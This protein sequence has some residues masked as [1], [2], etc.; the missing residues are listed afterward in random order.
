[1]KRIWL[2]IDDLHELCS[3][4]V[5]RQLELL[6]MRAPAELR[7][8]LVSRR[9]LHLGLHR[10]R[11]EGELTE[12]RAA[13]L[14]F[15]LDESRALF[16]SA[17]VQLSESGVALLAERTE[18]WAAGLR[19]AALSLAG[20]H[21][22]ER[23]AAAF[24]GSERTVAEYLVAEVLDRQPE[25]VRRLLLRTSVLERVSGPLADLLTGGSDGQRVL[26]E[27]EEAGA[28][29]VSLDPRR[30]WFRYHPLFADLLQLE[31]GGPQRTNCPRCTARPASGFRNT[32]TRLRRSATRRRRRSGPSLVACCRTTGSASS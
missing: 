22:P 9:E 6:L 19:L 27:L 1:M 12:I 7:F 20:H 32:G 11:L 10:L 25:Q 15:S 8:V 2:V 14:R 23:F 17:G 26:Q 18:G 24:A 16:E 31:L 4:D 5:F 28:F 13:D 29:V 30:S 3:D 21:D